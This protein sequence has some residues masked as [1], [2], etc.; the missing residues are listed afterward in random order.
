M[1]K[2]RVIVVVSALMVALVVYLLASTISQKPVE[3]PLE[4][5]STYFTDKTGAR[6]SLLLL[7]KA[8]GTG[9]IRQIQEPLWTVSYPAYGGPSTLIV[10]SPS[11]AL[12]ALEADE[13]ER[14]VE[15]GGQLVLFLENEWSVEETVP[16]L[17]RFGLKIEAKEGSPRTLKLDNSSLSLRVEN[18]T[19]CTGEFEPFLTSGKETLAISKERG[20]GRVVVFAD[21]SV[22]SNQS[23]GQADNAVWLVRLINSTPNNTLGVAVQLW[24]FDAIDAMP[25]TT[26]TIRPKPGTA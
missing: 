11:V 4:R 7:E 25:Y 19:S 21:S 6:A 12:Q 20:E 26:S 17:A 1:T 23:L 8:L 2:G 18:A 15:S 3:D 5:P 9:S 13:L 16:M 14:W 22:I 10:A 24:P